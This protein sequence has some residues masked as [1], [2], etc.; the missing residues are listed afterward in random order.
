MSQF[1]FLHPAYKRLVDFVSETV[2]TSYIKSYRQNE[3]KKQL[4]ELNNQYYSLNLDKET[5]LLELDV[6]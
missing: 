6:I 2:F 3:F 1:L 4:S 5:D